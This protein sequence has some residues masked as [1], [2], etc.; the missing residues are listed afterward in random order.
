MDVPAV[1]AGVAVAVVSCMEKGEEKEEEEDEEEG[2]G[3][4]GES[5]GEEE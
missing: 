1:E 4:D 2:V 5:V 3:E